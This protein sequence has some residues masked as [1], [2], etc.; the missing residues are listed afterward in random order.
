MGLLIIKLTLTPALMW[1][2][3]YV[4]RRWGS[5]TGGL[6]AGMPLT[7]AP[8]SIYLAAE[9]GRIFT[10]HAAVSSLA[11]VA[12][13]AL[14]SLAYAAAIQHFP[15]S[16]TVAVAIGSFFG[17][18]ILFQWFKPELLAG[19]IVDI[20]LISI[21]LRLIPTYNQSAREIIYP[22]WDLPARMIVSTGMVLL[23]TLSAP[24]LGPNLS[25]L[26]SPVPVLAWPLIVFVHSQQ[27]IK[28]ALEV[29]KGNLRGAYGIA[30]FYAF[31]A[32]LLPSCNPILTYVVALLSSIVATLPWMLRAR[33]RRVAN[34]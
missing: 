12:A 7:S 3:S 23:I 1:L 21:I 25:G 2:V 8:I 14:F 33:R 24:L 32:A 29:L 9:Q 18:L 6:I 22:K 10:A 28:G 11:G 17:G 19:F 4:S 34:N 26:L 30:L 15:I 5:T 31:V 20:I 16:L 13:V 27:G